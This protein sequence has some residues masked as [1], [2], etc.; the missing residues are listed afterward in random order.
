VA[1]LV[2]TST[3]IDWL[4]NK[5]NDKTILFDK[6]LDSSIPFGVSVLTYHE[7]LQGAKNEKEHSQLK[8]Y[9][10]TQTIYHLP[11][12]LDFFDT[13]TMMYVTLRGQGKT[14]RSTIDVIIAMT[15]IHHDLKLLHNDKDF[16]VIAN[17]FSEL[18]TL[19]KI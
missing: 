11:R 13:A 4:K 5:E 15:A 10:G 17:H 12:N 19:D 7:V 8:D 16:D 6:V 14:I 3:M 1:V 18:K 9:L 2:D